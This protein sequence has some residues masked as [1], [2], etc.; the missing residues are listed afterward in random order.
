MNAPLL[1]IV[2]DDAT[3][4][5]AAARC[6]TDGVRVIEAVD[7]KSALQMIEAESPDAVLTD[8]RMPGMTGLELVKQVRERW[9]RLP[10]VLMTSMGSARTAVQAL[11]AG[12]IS[13]VAKAE[14]EEQLAETIDEV[15]EL[16]AARQDEQRLLAR[17]VVHNSEFL[18]PNDPSLVL[19]AV[20]W[21]T[22]ELQRC[23][24]GDEA[25]RNQVGM[26]L[27]EALSNAMIHGNLALSSDLRD[28]DRSAYDAEIAWRRQQSPYS[29]RRV[30]CVTR[31][32][33]GTFEARIEDQGA[34]FDIAALPD[35]TQPENLLRARGRGVFL[36]HTFMD[37]V[38]YTKPGNA[39]TLR[40][41]IPSN[42]TA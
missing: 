38:E 25:T 14:L 35:P 28:R 40:K 15:I 8:L 16:V 39:V 1:L 18:L 29:D 13:F 20:T 2:D 33:S 6:L 36:I 30:R 7:G 12:A 21:I 31:V 23:D 37:E 42:P 24:F 9:P 19:P 3:D 22:A 34:G 41:R 11:H 4:R 10:V 5:A 17:L 27:S 32:E 26:A